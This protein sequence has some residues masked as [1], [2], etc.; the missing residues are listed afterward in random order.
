MAYCILK[1]VLF[2]SPAEQV[3]LSSELVHDS[4]ILI[5]E[6]SYFYKYKSHCQVNL[7]LGSNSKLSDVHERLSI[8]LMAPEVDLRQHQ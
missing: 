2:E 4:Q 7:T 3:N 1:T 5:I 8:D 6:A